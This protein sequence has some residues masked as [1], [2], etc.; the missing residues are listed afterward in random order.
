MGFT[1]DF[2]SLKD[3]L[4]HGEYTNVFFIEDIEK[5]CLDKQ[6]VKEALIKA[7]KEAYEDHF[8]CGVAQRVWKQLGFNSKE[9]GL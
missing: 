8:G 6:R 4:R 2:P 1:E 9:L 5:Y 7:Q 3:K